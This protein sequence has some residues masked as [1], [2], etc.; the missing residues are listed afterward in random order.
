MKTLRAEVDSIFIFVSIFSIVAAVFIGD[1][2]WTQLSGSQAWQ[3]YFGSNIANSQEANVVTNTTGAINILNNAIVIIFIMMALVSV[4]AA[5]FTESSPLFALLGVIVLPL[6]IIFAF[7]FHDL[8]FEIIQNSYFA[9]IAAT[10]PII[11][12]MFQYFPV[13]AFFLWFLLNLVIFLK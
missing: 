5:A 2:I 6:E 11:T 13:A 1:I 7:I 4:I 10:Y 9:P 12:T 3:T 8:Y